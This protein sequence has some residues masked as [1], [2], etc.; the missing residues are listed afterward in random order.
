MGSSSSLH[1]ALLASRLA[2]QPTVVSGA[3]SGAVCRSKKTELRRGN[4]SFPETSS[5][6]SLRALPLWLKVFIGFL[7]LL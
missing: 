5:A 6:H 1:P 7:F 2:D 3:A 4:G